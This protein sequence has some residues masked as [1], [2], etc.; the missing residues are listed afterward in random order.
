MEVVLDASAII[1]VI[2]DEP[3]GYEVIEL[4][5]D[6]KKILNAAQA[7]DVII[8]N[9]DGKSYGLLPVKNGNSPFDNISKVKLGIT[10]HEIVEIIR[11]CREGI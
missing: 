4:T 5:Q 6:T 9:D 8:N 11:E 3:E 10:T 2:A 7:N 1:S